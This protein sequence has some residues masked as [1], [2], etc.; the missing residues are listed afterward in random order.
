MHPLYS[1]RVGVPRFELGTPC[2]PCKCATK[3]RYT[4]TIASCGLKILAHCV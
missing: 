4:P 2:T 3:L 1:Y